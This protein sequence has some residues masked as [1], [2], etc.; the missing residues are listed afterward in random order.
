M[1]PPEHQAAEL[2]AI[3]QDRELIED[4]ILNESPSKTVATALA[5]AEED[6]KA[7]VARQIAQAEYDAKSR[8]AA[9]EHARQTFKRCR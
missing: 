3:E 9:Q 6:H 2:A 8:D 4:A 5:L 1:R 7:F